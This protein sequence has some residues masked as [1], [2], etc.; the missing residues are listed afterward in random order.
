MKRL[1]PALSLLSIALFSTAAFSQESKHSVGINVGIASGE[2]KNSS[3]DGDGFIQSYLYYNYQ[4]FEHI[5]FEI[6]YSGAT[7]FDDWDC[8]ED[9]DD[10]SWTCSFNS[11]QNIFN[12]RAN[13]FELNSAVIAI[14][15]NLPISKRNSLYGKIGAQ[16]YDYDFSLNDYNIEGD[17]G[18]GTLLEAGWQY[19]W[20][21]GIGMN[22]GLR[23]Q[24]LGDLS[25]ISSNVGIS[26]LF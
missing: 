19:Q 4:A 15:G 10:N 3:K 12:L 24:D 9:E 18:V 22:A 7:E 1:L 6:A 21:M 25:F 16:Y 26:Y 13:E 8:D 17:N 5:S 14:K 11:N 20:D 23:Y 2:Y